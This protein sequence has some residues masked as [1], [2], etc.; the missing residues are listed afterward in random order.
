MA[1]AKAK[2]VLTYRIV[3]DRSPGGYVT[4]KLI[5]REAQREDTAHRIAGCVDNAAGYGSADAAQRMLKAYAALRADGHAEYFDVAWD[6]VSVMLEFLVYG[7]TEN[8][9]RPDYCEP[10]IEFP[11]KFGHATRALKLLQ[12][13]GCRVEKTRAATRTVERG[14]ECD[15]S[16]VGN[17]SFSSLYDLTDALDALG[18]IRVERWTNDM[19][20]IDVKVDPAKARKAA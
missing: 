17:Y 6:G 19:L 3:R 15:P 7:K 5:I 4:D 2:E 11:T 12:R 8:D 20:C 16:E 10:S 1:K 9:E 18:A 14:Y 13:I